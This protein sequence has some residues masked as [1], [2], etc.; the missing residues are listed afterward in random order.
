ML[1]QKDVERTNMIRQISILGEQMK[2]NI[3]EMTP[4][5]KEKQQKLVKD[6]RNQL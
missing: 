5:Q 3:N 2:E 1:D 4:A 6:Y